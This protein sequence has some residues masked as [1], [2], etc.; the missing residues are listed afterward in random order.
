VASPLV[1]AMR[2]SCVGC[3]DGCLAYGAC[4]RAEPLPPAS[5]GGSA[6]RY[7][8][9]CRRRLLRLRSAPPS[10]TPAQTTNSS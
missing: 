2:R 4:S 9:R 7:D 6:T 8:R 10:A 5:Q 3:N 1:M